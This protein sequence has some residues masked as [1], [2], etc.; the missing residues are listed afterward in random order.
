MNSGNDIW[1]NMLQNNAVGVISKTRKKK[2]LLF[3]ELFRLKN[4][5]LYTD[6]DCC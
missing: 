3:L 2:F 1:E 5:R 6:W 4:F